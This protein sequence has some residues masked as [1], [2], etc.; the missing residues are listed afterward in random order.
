M[1]EFPSKIA[2]VYPSKPMSVYA[3]IWDGS[4]WA[5]HGGKYPVNYDYAPFVAQFAEM[6]VVGCVS[7]SKQTSSS[8]ASSRASTTSD[9]VGGKDFAVLSKQQTSAMAWARS[10]LMFY[11]Y[12]QDT[13]RYKVLPPEC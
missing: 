11:S 9:P 8:C 10:K 6:E 2:S 5:T 7:D 13:V 4:E 1:R 3:T 12:C